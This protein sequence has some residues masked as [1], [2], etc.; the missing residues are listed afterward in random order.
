VGVTPAS[1]ATSVAAPGD[2]LTLLPA[3]SFSITLTPG[4]APK[5]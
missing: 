2:Q 1:S 3:R 4:Y 5:L